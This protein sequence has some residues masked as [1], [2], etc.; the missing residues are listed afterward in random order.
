MAR[1]HLGRLLGLTSSGSL[2]PVPSA[3]STSPPAHRLP[4]SACVQLVLLKEESLRRLER[5]D[6]MSRARFATHTRFSRHVSARPKE[7]REA[8]TRLGFASTAFDEPATTRFVVPFA[9]FI[10]DHDDDDDDERA[11]SSSS[12]LEQTGDDSIIIGSG[13]DSSD[14]TSHNSNERESAAP[15]AVSCS[16]GRRK[17]SRV[18]ARS[19]DRAPSERCVPMLAARFSTSQSS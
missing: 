19:D 11:L 4:S 1:E 7:L 17:V 14:S 2:P 5:H 13:D 6:V 8:H 18:N 16:N 12:S 10:D 3:V 15:Q 9:L